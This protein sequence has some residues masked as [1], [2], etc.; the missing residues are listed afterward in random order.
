MATNNINLNPFQHLLNQNKHNYI[1]NNSHQTLYLQTITKNVES[2]E[3][4]IKKNCEAYYV[5]DFIQKIFEKGSPLTQSKPINVLNL[6]NPEAPKSDI[7]QNSNINVNPDFLNN[8]QKTLTE[9]EYLEKNS[10]DKNNP[11]VKKFNKL[12]DIFNIDKSNKNPLK[13]QQ[14]QAEIIN[15]A[16]DL[17]SFKDKPELRA[18]Y[19]E[20][21]VYVDNG[22]IK[23]NLLH[24]LSSN[25]MTE[26]L[27]LNAVHRHEKMDNLSGMN[28]HLFTNGARDILK[29]FIFKNKKEFEQASIAVLLKKNNIYPAKF[30]T[31]DEVR[32]L[33]INPSTTTVLKDVFKKYTLDLKSEGT[34]AWLEKLKNPTTSNAQSHGESLSLKPDTKDKSVAILEDLNQVWDNI[35]KN[36]PVLTS[37]V[38]VDFNKF[39]VD[40]L[41]YLLEPNNTSVTHISLSD[42]KEK[43]KIAEQITNMHNALKNEHNKLYNTYAGKLHQKRGFF[44]TTLIPD[45]VKSTTAHTL[46]E[47]INLYINQSSSIKLDKPPFQ[48]DMCKNI[49]DLEEHLS[50]INTNIMNYQEKLETISNIYENVEEKSNE[51]KLQNLNGANIEIAPQLSFFDGAGL[52][53][54]EIAKLIDEV[55]ANPLDND[56]LLKKINAEL[57]NCTNFISKVENLELNRQHIFASENDELDNKPPEISNS[58]GR[59]TDQAKRLKK[60]I[61]GLKG[62]NVAETLKKF[63]QNLIT[64]K[65]EIANLGDRYEV[66]QEGT[67]SS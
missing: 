12:C 46:R 26:L 62:D 8:L 1:Q 44:R 4:K 28:N 43:M 9:L 65:T 60:L 39:R 61:D 29:T 41:R 37:D 53:F 32:A 56:S 58:V 27:L 18:N 16:K 17:Q 25:T 31:L 20:Y 59:L 40:S 54:I 48:G 63:R 7:N 30:T 66:M 33:F 15:F 42:N 34:T 24:K 38:S 67:T 50:Q 45:E 11:D 21:L 10:T 55:H 6:K 22:E 52:N 35:R 57:V 49:N 19:L 36:T 64:S 3:Y 2:R 23:D 47:T 14:L 5:A 13:I 51:L